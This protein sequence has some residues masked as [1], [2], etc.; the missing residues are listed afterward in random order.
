V[1]GDRKFLL[2]IRSLRSLLRPP[3]VRRTFALVK[4]V[5]IHPT[6]VFSLAS[7][8]ILA[9]L[10]PW[11]PSPGATPNPR[12]LIDLEANLPDTKLFVLRP[13][14]VERIDTELGPPAISRVVTVEQGDTLL[15]LL[16]GAGIERGE[17]RKA[18]KALKKEYSP[19]DLKPGQAVRL[20]LAAD[21]LGGATKLQDTPLRLIS[22]SLQQDPARDI[23]VVRNRENERFV[24]KAID[25]PLTREIVG[26]S[27]VIN[28]SLFAAGTEAGAPALVMA[29]LIRAFSYDVDF[30]RE[31]RKA[32]D[33][34]LLYESQF[35]KTG[36]LA[37]TG[38]VI[39]AS[40]NLSDRPHDLY[41]FTP[42]SG[43][44]DYFDAQGRSARKSLL[45]TPIDGARI[46]S[47][48][49]MRKNPV[50]GFSKMHRGLDFAAVRGTPVYAAGDG[51]V[52]R[53]GR[54]DSFGNYVR[55]RHN[56]KYQTAYAHMDR[57]AKGITKGTRVKQGDVIGY[58]GSSGRSTGSHLH[59]EVLVNEEQVNPL[60]L[61][62]ASGEL[63][64]DEDLE[65]F[66]AFRARI[67]R[68]RKDMP[69]R[70]QIVQAPCGGFLSAADPDPNTFAATTATC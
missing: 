6:L 23:Y 27:A 47:L 10:G 56:G 46:S 57:I 49:G 44:P 3:P 35:D 66:M 16:T 30:Q 51:L 67:D 42:E 48:Y 29:E 21:A 2:S 28:S 5:L 37:E 18:I 65:R 53:A 7:L 31:V 69:T 34:E 68:L 11:L 8:L 61:E 39:F 55:I 54:W 36:A 64:Q 63:L 38:S 50:L 1:L 33:F 58:A 52:E 22:L 41:R 15:R 24:A 43:I 62:L 45:R 17:A 14:S 59:Y 32:D 40:L 19:R 60:K 4:P 12:P 70:I 26:G 13:M 9:A 20:A 25:R